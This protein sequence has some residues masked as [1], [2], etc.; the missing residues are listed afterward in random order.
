[1][2]KSMIFTS[3]AGL[4]YIDTGNIENTKS[5]LEDM[6]LSGFISPLHEP[7]EKNKIK[8]YHI[9]C[10]RPLQHGLGLKMWRDIA[11]T[12]EFLNGYVQILDYPHAYAKYLLHL[13]NPE[14][15]QFI[16]KN[17]TNINYYDYITT[18]GNPPKYEE[19]IM[20]DDEKKKTK[21]NKSE[22]LKD[23]IQYC[24]EFQITN[25]A[26]LCNIV[27]DQKPEWF[28]AC[29]KNS[30]PIIAYMRSMEYAF[31]SKGNVRGRDMLSDNDERKVISI[32]RGEQPNV[33]GYDIDLLTKYMDC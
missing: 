2:G 3:V 25:Y 6:G 16:D 10:I 20:I 24:N 30:T 4:V 9:Q 33:S 32:L 14:K 18:F 27:I 28:D 8:H 13:D 5:I 7:D 12:A 21:S 23:I 29:M 19:Y 17:D 11:N 26:S 31:G 22:I 1:M 15:Q